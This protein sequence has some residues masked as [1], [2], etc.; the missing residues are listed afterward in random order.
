MAW[1]VVVTAA[2]GFRS[3]VSSDGSIAPPRDGPDPQRDGDVGSDARDAANSASCFG[4]PPFDFCL[5]APP[6]GALTLSGTFSTGAGTNTTCESSGI[7]EKVTIGSVTACA[8]RAQGITVGPSSI[9]RVQGS[10]PLVIA[11]EDI[12][13][14]GTVVAASDTE[15]H[16]GPDANDATCTTAGTQG[17]SNGGCGGG[18]AGGSFGTAGGNGGTGNSNA[19][20]IGTATLAVSQPVTVLRGGCAGGGGGDG[21]GTGGA[22]APG[23]G[24]V[25]IIARGTLTISGVIDASGSGGGLSAAAKA[26]GGGGGSGGMIVLAAA[27]LDAAG[28]RVVAN[29]GGGGGGADMNS[30]G[31]TG[32]DPSEATVTTGAGGGG[33]GGG[34]GG[35]G[36]TG[37]AAGST[38][39]QGTNAAGGGGGGGGGGGEGVVRVLG[40]QALT[41]A[42]VSP[43]ST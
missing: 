30:G 12:T 27:M 29:G 14:A 10:I 39:G 8:I 37:A 36:G 18:G 32:S 42:A 33:G 26:G 40:G 3:G 13:I 9:F 2:C 11:A 17:S 43:S 35:K 4:A 6:T 23:G 41:G 1:V 28:A 38:G 15:G 5:A 16:V 31:N 22:G 19:G 7:G 24:A 21:S 34:A 20:T 25:Y